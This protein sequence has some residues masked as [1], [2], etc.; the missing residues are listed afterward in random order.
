MVDAFIGMFIDGDVSYEDVSGPF[1]WNSL[2]FGESGT[3][4]SLSSP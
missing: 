1:S 3:D 4:G 2:F